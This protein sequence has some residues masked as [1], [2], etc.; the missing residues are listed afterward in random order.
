MITLSFEQIILI[1][2]I[3]LFIGFLKEGGGRNK[4]PSNSY[5]NDDV[6]GKLESL[7]N[8]FPTS[9]DRVQVK[10]SGE[11]T[12]N[13]LIGIYKGIGILGLAILW[14]TNPICLIIKFAFRNIFNFAIVSYAIYK[15]LETW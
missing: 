10:D 6:F 7:E 8:M 14:I 9:Y 15:V 12:E 4:N 2:G 5:G 3:I 13:S 1:I 11:M